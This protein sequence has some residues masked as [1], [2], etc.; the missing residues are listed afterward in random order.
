MLRLAVLLSVLALAVSFSWKLAAKRA[1]VPLI[2]SAGMLLS[3]PSGASAA[4]NRDVYFGVGCFWHVQH[5][6]VQAEQNILGRDTSQVTSAAGYAGSTKLGKNS[7]DPT[8][9]G[10]VCY[11][12][13]MGEGDYGKLGHGEVV[14]MQVSLSLEERAIEGGLFTLL[15]V[16][17]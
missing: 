16:V 14:G 12:N 10:I 7:R 5:E 2:A 1:A 15:L 11:H 9:K 13:L 17:S 8:S 3:D 4:V 6:F